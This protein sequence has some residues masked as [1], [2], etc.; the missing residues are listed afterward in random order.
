MRLCYDV[1][2]IKN[3]WDVKMKILT[4]VGTAILGATL[5]SGSASSA[6]FK[7]IAS[8]SYFQDFSVRQIVAGASKNFA[9]VVDYTTAPIGYINFCSHGEQECRF[10]TGKA[11]RV[12]LQPEQLEQLNQVNTYVNTKIKPVSDAETY[13]VPDHWSYPVSSGD[14]EDYVLLK[15][16]YLQGLGFSP[17]QLLIT[18]VLDENGAGHAI[19]TVMTDKG[20]LILD[21]RRNQILN[22]NKTGY[23]FLKR[24]SQADASVWVSLRQN[25]PQVLVSS[26]SN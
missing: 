8:A 10:N 22:W 7:F 2:T 25:S 11:E 15:K 13:G 14:C 12:S 26:Q 9:K 5:L 21:N 20:D 16:R 18:V 19:L 3:E 24:Q 6:N 1:L 17:E 4:A 23:K